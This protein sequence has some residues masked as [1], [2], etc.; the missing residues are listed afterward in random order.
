MN[1]Y[2]FKSMTEQA[3]AIQKKLISPVELLEEFFD[4]IKNEKNS[5]QIFSEI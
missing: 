4:N 5:K 1:N 2:S 3:I